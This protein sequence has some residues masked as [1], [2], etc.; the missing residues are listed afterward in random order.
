[1]QTMPRILSGGMSLPRL[2]VCPAI[3][4]SLEPKRPDCATKTSICI[5]NLRH[6]LEHRKASPANC[7]RGTLL[8][9]RAQ[10]RNQVSEPIP[11]ARATPSP[12]SRANSTNRQTVGTKFSKPTNKASKTRRSSRS[13]KPSSSPRNCV[14]VVAGI[15]DPGRITRA[16]A[17]A[18]PATAS[19]CHSEQL[20]LPRNQQGCRAT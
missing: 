16:T 1:M 7:R 15:G 8:Q 19:R 10:P 12:R 5:D 9:Q 2:R 3:R 11:S 13:G 4:S 20:A 6:A 14:N 18:M 17:S